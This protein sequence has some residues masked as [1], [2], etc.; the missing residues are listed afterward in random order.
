MAFDK[1]T[2]RI[3]GK[4]SKRTK[5]PELTELRKKFSELIENNQDNIQE[6]LDRVA[7][8]DPS[9]ALDLLLK[10]SSFV[11]PKPRYIETPNS[12][13]DNC[14]KILNIDPIEG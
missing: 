8:D 2:A 10:M 14:V 3:A 4:R 7:M 1:E 5:D 11:L 12:S 6:W 9:K 13:V